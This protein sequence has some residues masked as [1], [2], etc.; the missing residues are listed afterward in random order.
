M[1]IREF[2]YQAQK[3]DLGILEVM[4]ESTGHEINEYL[5]PEEEDWGDAYTDRTTNLYKLFRRWPK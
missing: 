2:A 3:K 5:F 1:D 4:A